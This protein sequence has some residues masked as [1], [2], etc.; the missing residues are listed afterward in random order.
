LAKLNLVRSAVR[1]SVN[2]PITNFDLQPGNYVTA[3]KGVAALIDQDSL[4][5]DG[6]F[7]ETKLAADPCG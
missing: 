7:E 3:G 4:H 2:S 1:A 5:V 6:Y